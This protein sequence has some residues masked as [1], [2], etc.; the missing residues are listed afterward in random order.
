MNPDELASLVHKQQSERDKEAREQREKEEAE[1]RA[2]EEARAKREARER[3]GMGRYVT[4][5]EKEDGS[6]HLT[7][8]CSGRRGVAKHLLLW[9]GLL[10]SLSFQVFLMIPGVLMMVW[11]IYYFR[12][13]RT[14]V[15]LMLANDHFAFFIGDSTTP[16]CY[17][18]KRDL[19][20][21][22][23]DKGNVVMY[24]FGFAP[25]INTH[26]RYL[27][28]SGLVEGITH[29]DDLALL[30]SFSSRLPKV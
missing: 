2:Q 9:F 30:A 10:L 16:R 24:G 5:E 23:Y 4:L 14:K 17:G 1:K 29:P 28:V 27:S 18:A 15:R 20:L 26:W 3:A 25:S 13:P 21:R 6:S 8:L 11:G 22:G 12:H 19:Y 7:Y